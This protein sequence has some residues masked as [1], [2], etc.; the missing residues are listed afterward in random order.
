MKKIIVCF[1]CCQILF[2]IS[3]LVYSDT[4]T[5]TYTP[6]PTCILKPDIKKV[7]IV[8][9]IKIDRN[10]RLDNMVIHSV[11][12]N[13]ITKQ[14]LDVLH[15]LR[16][17]WSTHLTFSLILDS[18]VAWKTEDYD[19]GFLSQYFNSESEDRLFNEVILGVNQDNW[20]NIQ[21]TINP[22]DEQFIP[23]FNHG[24]AMQYDLLHLMVNSLN[25]RFSPGKFISNEVLDTLGYAIGDD[26]IPASNLY[27]TDQQEFTAQKYILAS[28]VEL[29]GGVGDELDFGM[30]HYC[31]V[32]AFDPL[33]YGYPYLPRKFF[34]PFQSCYCEPFDRFYDCRTP[35]PD[36][37]FTLFQYY[38]PAHTVY[39]KDTLYKHGCEYGAGYG[40]PDGLLP[41]NGL[42][43]QIYNDDP[44]IYDQ[45]DILE[46]AIDFKEEDHNAHVETWIVFQ[47]VFHLSDFISCYGDKQMHVYWENLYQL[48]QLVRDILSNHSTDCVFTSNTHI[49]NTIWPPP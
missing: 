17:N 45:R 18:C 25:S 27:T 43:Y 12:V 4:P 8:L 6:I 16:N 1:M 28:S 15:C 35:T 41:L 24:V 42:V 38:I 39:K 9:T 46:R 32:M 19:S 21:D 33:T 14:V 44:I 20:F 10:N 49:Y 48:D 2:A 23:I 11:V 3:N 34:K 37:R 5:P 40:D 26:P 30:L 22:D 29:P 31:Q 47:P 36:C 7:N 13:D